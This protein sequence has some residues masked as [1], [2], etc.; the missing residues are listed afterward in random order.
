M[1]HSRTSEEG[2]E[3]SSNREREIEKQSYHHPKFRSRIG[4]PPSLP[5]TDPH[6]RCR[7]SATLARKLETRLPRVCSVHVVQF[8]LVIGRRRGRLLSLDVKVLDEIGNVIVI[9]LNIT[10]CWPLLPLLDR[11]VGFC[12][13][14]Q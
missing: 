2:E 5:A 10:C 9:V 13:L 3:R 6:D 14:A 11:L 4:N 7:Q 8:V 12:E 1:D